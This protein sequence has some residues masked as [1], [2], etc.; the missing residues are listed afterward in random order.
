MRLQNFAM[1]PVPYT[2]YNNLWD[3]LVLFEMLLELYSAY[4]AESW[5]VL[6][7]D[8][9]HLAI[10]NISMLNFARASTEN[11][12]RINSQLLHHSPCLAVLRICRD[13]VLRVFLVI[14][15]SLLFMWRVV[16]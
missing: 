11:L 2:R 5:A 10:T 3:S 6:T 14:L 8:S 7:S 15:K 16:R 9:N 12:I 4:V 1:L 13:V